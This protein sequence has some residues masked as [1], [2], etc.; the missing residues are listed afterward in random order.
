MLQEKRG[1]FCVPVFVVSV[2]VFAGRL[3]SMY[4]ACAGNSG[5]TLPLA[6]HIALRV[7]PVGEDM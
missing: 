2:L 7:C 1:V 4:F 5:R 6:L 3:P